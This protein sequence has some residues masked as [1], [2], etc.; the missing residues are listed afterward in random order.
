MAYNKV[1]ISGITT[2][3]I[4]V[5]KNS[6]MIELFNRYKNGDE[7]AKE[8]I[9]NGNLKLVLSIIQRFKNKQENLDDLF[10]IGC[11]GLIKAVDNFDLS[12]GVMFSTYA[13][14]MILGEIKRY[15]RDNNSLRISRSIKDNSFKIMK[16]KDSFLI[17]YEREPTTEEISAALEIPEIDVITAINSMKEPVSIF[18]PIYQDGGDTIYLFDQIENPKTKKDLDELLNMRKALMKIKERERMILIERFIIGK[19][20]MEIAD[21]MDISQAQV[22]RLE[23]SAIKNVKR[24]MS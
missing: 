5:L 7:L 10:Q 12:H 8:E 20:Q 6:E 9:I 19:T 14:P 13:V 24:L 4:R 1:E 3:K 21:T 23:K 22:S 18:E 16:F 15:I 2:S 11:V 17:D